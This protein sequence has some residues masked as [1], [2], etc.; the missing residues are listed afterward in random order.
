VL[1]SR[2]R[3]FSEF[4][5]ELEETF[6]ERRL[7]DTVR[8]APRDHDEV[9]PDGHRVLVAA[10]DFTKEALHAVAGYGVADRAGNND[11]EA[12]RKGVAAQADVQEEPTAVEPA[13]CLAGCAEIRAAPD[14]L[15]GREP[16]ADLPFLRQR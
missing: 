11:P 4:A 3:I 9:D 14:P 15:R 12:R 5:D 10:E 13:A 7:V 16:E 2:G 8:R 6:L 1:A